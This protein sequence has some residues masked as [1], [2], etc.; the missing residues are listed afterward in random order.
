MFDE[1]AYITREA[2]HVQRLESSLACTSR[3]VIDGVLWGTSVAHL[4]ADMGW[5]PLLAIDMGLS[6]ATGKAFHGR[7][8]KQGPVLAYGFR[9]GVAWDGRC[10]AWRLEAG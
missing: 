10:E 8:V 5:S 6:V 7:S 1:Y 3:P 9:P 4:R 2:V